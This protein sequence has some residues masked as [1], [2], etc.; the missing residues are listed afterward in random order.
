MKRRQHAKSGFPTRFAGAGSE[1]VRHDTDSMF[2][3]PAGHG[4]S[5]QVLVSVRMI[6][7][8]G[9]VL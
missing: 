4:T 5:R 9:I 6:L 3:A 8:G 1:S 2:R 7:G